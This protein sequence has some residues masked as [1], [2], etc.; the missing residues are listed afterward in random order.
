MAF[1][2][3]WPIRSKLILDN[4]PVEQV[5]RFNY[6]GCQFSYQG[7]VDVDHKLGKFNY[8]CGTI[9]QT[10]KNKKNGNTD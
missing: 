7:E 6:L 10:L 4:Q 3:K 9:K 1:C 2:D 8:M 5:F